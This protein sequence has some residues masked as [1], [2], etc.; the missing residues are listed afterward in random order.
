MVSTVG[1]MSV[2][3][4][5]SDDNQV[6]VRINYVP[7][8]YVDMGEV[9]VEFDSRLIENNMVFGEG[10]IIDFAFF[11]DVAVLSWW[12]PSGIVAPYDGQQCDYWY[13][14]VADPNATCQYTETRFGGMFNVMIDGFDIGVSNFD[15]GYDG[16]THQEIAIQLEKG[17]H[18][19]TI[20]AAELVSDCNRTEGFHW[21]YAKDQKKFYI[22]ED[23]DD[24]TPTLYDA[25]FN[26]INVD[27]TGVISDD[28][29]LGYNISS[30]ETIHNQKLSQ[31]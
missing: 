3:Q 15:I 23:K 25:Y 16:G 30:L 20:V 31:H 9:Y 12:H 13:Y 29:D 28:L 5:A 24:D 17:W 1:A 21:E 18:Y 27:Q 10:D 7:S 14:D 26:D 6:E 8:A 19:I 22:S 2:T 11:Y 4:A